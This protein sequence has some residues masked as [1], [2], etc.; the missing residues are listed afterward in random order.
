MEKRDQQGVALNMFI[1]EDRR[2]TQRLLS[3]SRLSTRARVVNRPSLM[4]LRE[5]H[6]TQFCEHLLIR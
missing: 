1:V 6:D 4:I 2:L 5:Q 3:A